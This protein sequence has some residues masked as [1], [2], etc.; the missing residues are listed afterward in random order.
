MRN[1]TLS[2]ETFEMIEKLLKDIQ[3][4]FKGTGETEEKKE[5][6]QKEATGITEAEIIQ[7]FYKRLNK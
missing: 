1:G 4:I 6:E 5:P 3:A 7:Q 2:D